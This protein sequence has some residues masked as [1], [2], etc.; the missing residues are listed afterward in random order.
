MRKRKRNFKRRGIQVSGRPLDGLKRLM[1]N[2]MT[3][4]NPIYNDMRVY[5]QVIKRAYTED[6]INVARLSVQRD[7]EKVA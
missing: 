1:R 4:D 2:F 5:E 6:E 3:P 7:M